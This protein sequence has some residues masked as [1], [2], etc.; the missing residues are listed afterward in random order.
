M[1]FLRLQKGKMTEYFGWIDNYQLALP[2]LTTRILKIRPLTCVVCA[3][4]RRSF[5]IPKIK[6]GCQAQWQ[7]R[8]PL[9]SSEP[10]KNEPRRSLHRNSTSWSVW[11]TGCL[12][13]KS[14]SFRLRFVLFAAIRSAD[15]PLFPS[16]PARFF[17]ILG[18]NWVR[19]GE[20]EPTPTAPRSPSR[21]RR[22][23]DRPQRPRR[24]RSPAKYR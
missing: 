23:P 21:R 7:N 9:N 22:Q 17:R 5:F 12:K 3:Q 16:S 2:K 14:E 24:W 15:F 18:Q 8:K 10:T 19:H 13:G 20:P 6:K 4:S 1:R 11:R